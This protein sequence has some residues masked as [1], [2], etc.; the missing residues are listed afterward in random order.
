[1]QNDFENSRNITLAFDGDRLS[2]V[3]RRYGVAE[4]SLFGSFARNDARSASDVD[5]IYVLQDGVRMGFAL[6]EFEE[7]LAAVFGRPVD[8]L[9]KTSI[10]HLLR[11]DVLN[12]ARRLYAA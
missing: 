10:H 12:D 9:D 6:F 11:D 3:C 1:M 5:L 8:L 7:D 4:L 2:E